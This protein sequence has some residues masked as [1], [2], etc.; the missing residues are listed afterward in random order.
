MMSSI[1]SSAEELSAREAQARNVRASFESAGFEPVATPVLQPA[2]IFLDRSGEDIRRRTYL[3]SDPG[4]SELC[5]RPELTIPV[6]RH[7]L[8]RDPQALAPA[9]LCST[10]TI[11]RYQPEGSEK[12]NEYSQCGLEILGDVDDVAADAEVT[13]L[14]LAA[15][16]AA[17][18]SDY[19]IQF[20]D[21]ALFGALVDALNVPDSWRAK[22]KRQFWR[23]EFFAD[24]LVRLSNGGVETEP[25][26]RDGLLTVLCQLNE[27]QAGA[28]LSDVLKMGGIA[29]VGGRGIDEIAARLLEKA[30]DANT[31]AMPKE[32]ATL[33]ADFMSVTGQ[34]ADAV[35]EIQSLTKA[36]GVSISPA[37]HRLVERLEALS[38]A[39]VKLNNATF[40]TGFGRKLEY[41]TGHVFEV[42]VPSLG[43]ESAL[44][45][46]GRYDT[47]LQTLGAD[48]PVPAVGCAV[49][50]E[51]LFL[52]TAG[53][54]KQ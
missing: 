11:F 44:V 28:L 48:R 1:S 23:P 43:Q 35:A 40:S 50:L 34:P 41:Y 20:G 15:I 2:D 21:L 51:R 31:E 27:D 45:G 12:L 5:L 9:R 10:G 13:R 46:G 53:G 52:A 17:G 30:G 26:K 49:A 36:A 14:G 37:L 7:Y 3:F 4:G 16:E 25:E 22:L 42:T 33:I 29:P 47:L 32:A 18:V 8:A 39:G 24:L 6:C 54:E 19:Q 38:K